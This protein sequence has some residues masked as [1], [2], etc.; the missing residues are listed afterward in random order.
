MEMEAKPRPEMMQE[1]R[2]LPARY[3]TDPRY[4][5]H[6]RERFYG[7]RWF[8]AGR[9]EQVP[10]RGDYFLCEIADESLIVLRDD[11]GTIRS[12]FNVCR[13]R[14]TRMCVA[15]EG[16]FA[17]TI[18]CPY[19]AWAYDLE[20]RLVGAP[21]MEG[22]PHFRKEDHPLGVVHAEVWDGHIFLNL[23]R[24]PKPLGSQLNDLPAKF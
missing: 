18:P 15:A 21:H 23:A 11:R 3:Y 2:T 24:E 7:S 6:E 9:A 1:C 10:G 22:V 12:F 13:H 16:T 20:G 4:F 8:C 19:H 14:G 17:G 5:R